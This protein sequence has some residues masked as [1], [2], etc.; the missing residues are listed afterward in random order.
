MFLHF[1]LGGAADCALLGTFE[2]LAGLGVPEAGEG[3]VGRNAGPGTLG[4]LVRFLRG[5]R[6]RRGRSR[7][8]GRRRGLLRP[9]GRRGPAGGERGG[10]GE[11]AA[12]GHQVEQR[13]QLAGSLGVPGDSG[14]QER[15]QG[16]DQ[17]G[18][19][20][21]GLLGWRPGW[22]FLRAG[23]RPGR[24]RGLP[25]DLVIG[26]FVVAAECSL[27]TLGRDGHNHRGG[28]AEALHGGGQTDARA[29]DDLVPG[30]GGR[31]RSLGSLS[32]LDLARSPPGGSSGDATPP[33]ARADGGPVYLVAEQTEEARHTGALASLLQRDLVR[34]R[35][36]GRLLLLLLLLYLDGCG[37]L[38]GVHHLLLLL[39]LLLLVLSGV[40]LLLF[41]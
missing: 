11:E 17:G 13:H 5:P 4:P 21:P 20:R 28:R 30:P 12:A 23:R 25:L 15:A 24:W 38:C 22:L 31:G 3:E 19:V 36:F 14:Q 27:L 16:L 10:A 37:G 1:R 34:L 29:A 40:L 18:H 26:V 8:G 39:F 41:V 33:T 32:G 2:Q 9:G 6:S 35:G 7:R